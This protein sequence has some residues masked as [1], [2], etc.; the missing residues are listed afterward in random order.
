M[1]GGIKADAKTSWGTNSASYPYIGTAYITIDFN[2]PVTQKS[3]VGCPTGQFW[4]YNHL[5]PTVVHEIGHPMGLNDCYPACT[6]A[7]IMGGND[8]R[9]QN[10]TS[11]DIAVAKQ[12]YPTPTPTPTPIPEPTV[13]QDSEGDG[14]CSDR[15]CNDFNPYETTCNR[16]YYENPY[17]YGSSYTCF[18]VYEEQ[19]TWTCVDRQCSNPIT[20]YVFV[21]SYCS[22]T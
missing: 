1:S 4:E 17:Y 6:G 20:E 12:V 19:T 16:P 14:W 22:L 11:C 21:Y 3:Y 18:N 10:L 2:V 9:V 13:C 7:S 8:P 15:D 5:E